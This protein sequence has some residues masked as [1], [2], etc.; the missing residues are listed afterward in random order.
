MDKDKAQQKYIELLTKAE[1]A[2]GRKEAVKLIRKADK[3]RMHIGE[4]QG[5]TR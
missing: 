5:T 2:S 4:D 1:K 3:V